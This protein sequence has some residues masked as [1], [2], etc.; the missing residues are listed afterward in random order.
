MTKDYKDRAAPPT[1]DKVQRPGFFLF[2]AGV[3]VGA[4]AVGLISLTF[5]PARE[6][7]GSGLLTLPEVPRP[8]QEAP[9]APPPRD[10]LKFEFP[11]M[12]RTMEVMVP[13]E[14]LDAPSKPAR[15]P[16]PIAAPA[17]VAVTPPPAPV[18]PPSP[19]QPKPR[20]SS[21]ATPPTGRAAAVSQ[22]TP[23][24][25]APKGTERDSFVLQLGAFRKTSDLQQ[26]RARLALLGIET[27]VQKVTINNRDTFHRLRTAPFRSQQDLDKVRRV[28]TR[29]KIKSIVIR[30]KG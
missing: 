8:V 9:K 10:D 2:F 29:H 11:D 21:P 16:R 20:S 30:W 1:R 4:F 19:P 7:S 13:E 6:R 27:R 25:N 18:A 23:Q 22:V 3:L 15:P 26:L 12:L 28:L 5:E 24:P 14:D 17:Q